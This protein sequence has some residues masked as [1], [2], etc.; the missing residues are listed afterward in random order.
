M[1]DHIQPT[2]SV[3]ICTFNRCNDLRL[4]LESI[5]LDTIDFSRTWELL[6]IDNNSTDNTSK[7][8]QQ[9][10]DKLPLRYLFE[11]KQGLSH[12]RNRAIH[13]AK[14]SILV[15]TD[16]DVDVVPGWLA[17]YSNAFE[18]NPNLAF[19]GGK[20]IPTWMGTPP[21]WFIANAGSHLR[22]ITAWYDEGNEF[23]PYSRER[24]PFYGANIGFRVEAVKSVNGF[25]PDFGMRGTELG[26]GEET[27]T[28]NRLFTNGFSGL[29][30]P[31]AVV[32]H[33]IYPSRWTRR[34]ILRYA[35]AN[36]KRLSK[37]NPSSTSPQVINQII[38]LAS[39]LSIQ[40]L[41]LFTFSLLCYSPK[42]VS[43]IW[44]LGI[45]FGKLTEIR[46]AIRRHQ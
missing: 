15:F 18:E 19:A 33:R 24:E 13:E 11:P 3:A 25:D 12:A 26:L 42:W 45:S 6:I 37:L 2:I 38:E 8:A 23:W 41:Q 5:S 31:D 34:H 21:K 14:S 16:D 22:G 7:I 46:K 10:K 36:G 39:R 29:Y 28:I 30:I 9:F 4:T 35:I 44:H 27:I 1:T 40:V 17:S 32:R 43:A 20:I